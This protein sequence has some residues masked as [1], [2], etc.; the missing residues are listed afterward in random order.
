MPWHTAK[1]FSDLVA[2]NLQFLN[3]DLAYTPYHSGPLME[4]S[5]MIQSH[6]VNMCKD[7]QVVT[8]NSQP[9][10]SETLRRQR[11]YVDLFIQVK[12]PVDIS[13]IGAA[14]Q[15]EDLD[16]SIIMNGS[17]EVLDCRGFYH[18]SEKRSSGSKE[19]EG[20]TFFNSSDKE[21]LHHVLSSFDTESYEVSGG[22]ILMVF[23]ADSNW[24]M[25]V[26]HCVTAVHRVLKAFF[27]N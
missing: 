8:L 6:L 27:K 18:L 23:V 16:Y 17:D 22:N 21:S 19:W 7:L 2:L 24:G 9:A 26:D 5:N 25:E 15:E 13:E 11:G 12:D 14:L 4:E 20:C 3:R 1:S 10:Y